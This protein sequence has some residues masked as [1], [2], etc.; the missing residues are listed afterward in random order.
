VVEHA[1][2]T[3]GTTM[4]LTVRYVREKAGDDGVRQMLALAG[5]DRSAADLE[6]ECR[7]S[8]HEQKIALWEAAARVLDDPVVSRHIGESALRHSVG[9]SL[10]VLLRTL[11]SP[12][13]VLS[14]IAKASPKF[15]TVATMD[16]VEIGRSSA[17]VTYELHE[18]HRPHFLDCQ[19]NIGLISVIGPLFGMPPLAVAHPECQVDGAPRCRYE[20]RWSPRKRWSS[21][22]GAE[23]NHL[24]ERLSAM[25]SQLES[26]QSTAADLVADDD[27]EAVLSRI[28]ARAGVAIRAPRYLLALG[29][30]DTARMTVHA[31]GFASHAEAV[32]VGRE[33]LDAPNRSRFDD[34]MVI[35]VA[36]SRR[37][38]GRLAA[39]S[40]GHTF[41]DEE[42]RL[43]SA[44]ARSAAAA[45]D[46]ATAL[47]DARQR[48]A[49]AQALL[50]LAHAL[51]EVS[52]AP[53]VAQ[54]LA[55]AMPAVVN[56]QAGL[57]FL[58]DR[59]AEALAMHGR[60]GWPD[61]VHDRIG[62]LVLRP[63]DNAA[64]EAFVTNPEPALIRMAA[65]DPALRAIAESL[66]VET[67]ACVPIEHHGELL[68]LAVAGFPDG[69][70]P[71]AEAHVLGRMAGVADQA[72]TALRNALLLER[73]RGQALHDTLTGLANRALFE[74]L[75]TASLARSSRD[76]KG[77]ALLFVDLDR[78]K[79]IN[80][81]LG[82]DHGDRLL[83]EVATRL[84]DA[85]RAGDAL[86]RLGGDEFG[87][88]LHDVDR[89]SALQLA[90]RIRAALTEPVCLEEEPVV[91][92][93]SVG[94]A[95]F[96][97]DGRTYDDL[98]RHADMAMYD[99]KE[100]GRNTCRE[101]RAGGS[102]L[103][104]SRLALETDLRNALLEE[105]LALVF[106]PAV[107]LG[108]DRVVAF[109][110][111]VRWD[112]PVLSRLGPN[113]F[114]HTADEAG[115]SLAVDAWV[116]RSACRHANRWLRE[117]PDLRVSVN[118]A[119]A[120]CSR[121]EL[122]DAVSVALRESG[123]DPAALELEISEAAAMNAS[124]DMLDVLA[125]IRETGVSL[126]LDDFGT[127]YSLFGRMRGFSV[128]RVK[129]DGS[130]VRAP[131]EAESIVPAITGMCHGL[132]LEVAAVGV[133]TAEQLALVQRHGCDIA[134]GFLLGAPVDA[135]D[136]PPLLRASPL[137]DLGPSR[138]SQSA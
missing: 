123:L 20:V 107:D 66:E 52:S 58:W 137:A 96:P 111:L 33:L 90:E 133:E 93:A 88:M 30:T 56:A 115:L 77:P 129:I 53:D 68:G 136:V 10:R 75:V 8:T 22:R 45:L 43:L 34:A 42:H 38:Y 108:D 100:R 84:S 120:N 48:G 99:A 59:E 89:P 106:Q 105:Q 135:A 79:R 15:S 126:A 1:R 6:D 23:R 24:E 40:D 124:R 60:H 28:V 113:R 127:A 29:P 114:L 3:A 98:L 97:D 21:T 103:G 71:R 72:A 63:S 54:K 16:A 36:S 125:G 47:E 17:V 116:L 69:T 118:I 110:A 67:L 128:E 112:H 119:A 9:A 104:R 26:L 132:G 27:V 35:D 46:A 92:S 117:R 82:H 51:A 62:A 121:P 39:F 61:H 57:V 11:G 2:E 65:V 41:F 13:L 76:G 50:D 74:E 94:I 7:W 85:L 18:P 122:V 134:Q 19:S 31:D 4:C 37:T 131:D 32:E 80:D 70:S 86:A 102:S 101:Y 49:T 73:V 130:F 55:E 5:E 12:R 44:Y 138:M 64:V 95:V 78:F 83:C 91:V 109:E 25:S 87:V 81:S 14:N